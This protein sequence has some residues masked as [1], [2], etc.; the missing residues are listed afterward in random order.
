MCFYP[1]SFISW[2]WIG[3]KTKNNIVEKAE[4]EE[5]QEWKSNKRFSVEGK[6]KIWALNTVKWL[7]NTAVYSRKV[8]QY[9]R[10]ASIYAKTIKICCDPHNRMVCNEVTL[11]RIM[12]AFFSYSFSSKL[13]YHF[14]VFT[15]PISL[16]SPDY[17]IQT[18]HG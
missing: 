11:S 3:P 6:W 17:F 12:S 4:K 13:Q 10:S 16:R 2:A 18:L 15:I 14:N 7:L 5:E 9:K 1:K 8:N